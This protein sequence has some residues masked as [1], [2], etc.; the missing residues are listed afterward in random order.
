[1]SF[2]P[3]YSA[4][5]NVVSHADYLRYPRVHSAGMLAVDQAGLAQGLPVPVGADREA[6]AAL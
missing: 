4:C 5:L 6:Q 3:T 1:M 2:T